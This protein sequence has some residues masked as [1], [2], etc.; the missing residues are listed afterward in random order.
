MLTYIIT[1]IGL[2]RLFLINNKNKYIKNVQRCDDKALLKRHNKCCVVCFFLY[3]IYTIFLFS[4][5]VCTYKY[6]YYTIGISCCGCKKNLKTWE[7]REYFII[8]LLEEQQKIYALW[9]VYYV[10]YYY[11]QNDKQN[12]IL[13]KFNIFMV[14]MIKNMYAPLLIQIKKKCHTIL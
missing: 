9:E 3:S 7:I 4:F 2:R 1:C 6:I 10:Y 8:S 13:Y 5:C 12:I 11:W 14:M